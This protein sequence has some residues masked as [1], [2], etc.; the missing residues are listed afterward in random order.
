MSRGTAAE[1]LGLCEETD[2]TIGLRSSNLFPTTEGEECCVDEIEDG[3]AVP[4]PHDLSS[5]KCRPLS[6]SAFQE[7]TSQVNSFYGGSTDKVKIAVGAMMIK[8]RDMIVTKGKVN[9]TIDLSDGV[10]FACAQIV[11]LHNSAFSNSTTQFT[12]SSSVGVTVTR[13]PAVLVSSTPRNRLKRKN[14]QRTASNKRNTEMN[15]LSAHIISGVKANKRTK[16]KCCSFCGLN[17]G[18]FFTCC[19]K[20]DKHKTNANGHPFQEYDMN[21]PASRTMLITII[22]SSMTIADNSAELPRG[23]YSSLDAGW[24]KCSFIIKEARAPVGGGWSLTQIVFRLN[25]IGSDGNEDPQRQDK[26]VTGPVM[27]DM[28]TPKGHGNKPKPKFAYDHTV[29]TGP[30]VR[31]TMAF[32][33][34]SQSNG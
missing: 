21:S 7:V 15:A 34:L 13:P 27:K 16:G 31:H 24:Y 8:M 18:H 14:D 29:L 32:S 22:E 11:S 19:P 4:N 25:F 28:I 17:T 23:V 9:S 20:R 6:T 30:C 26:W 5:N 12:P 33:H 1:Q 10:E 2:D 3:N